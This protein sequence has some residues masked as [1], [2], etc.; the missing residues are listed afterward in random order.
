[1]IGS[2][3]EDKVKYF[4]FKFGDKGGFLALVGQGKKCTFF[5]L[6][7]FDSHCLILIFLK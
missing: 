7:K 5:S 6:N 3:D 4:F 2:I 1:M